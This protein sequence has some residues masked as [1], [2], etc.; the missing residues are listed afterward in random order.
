M[1]LR[2]IP[3]V[4]LFEIVVSQLEDGTLGLLI[5]LIVIDTVSNGE[6][7]ENA[8]YTCCSETPKSSTVLLI[9]LLTSDTCVTFIGSYVSISGFSC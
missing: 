6:Q 1:A 8:P 2:A 5:P 9:R 7:V 4:R 3:F